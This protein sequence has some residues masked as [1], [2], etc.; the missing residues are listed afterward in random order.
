[1]NDP[2]NSEIARL[3]HDL[4]WPETHA[5]DRATQ[6]LLALGTPAVPALIETLSGDSFL[7]RIRAAKI[8]GEIGD[9]RAVQPLIDALRRTGFQDTDTGVALAG[10]LARLAEQNPVPTLRDALPLMNSNLTHFG[11]AAARLH[12]ALA[13]LPEDTPHTPEWE[14][15]RLVEQLQS[16]VSLRRD[17]VVR[18]L[19]ELGAP[20]VSPLIETLRWSPAPNVREA[21]SKILCAIGDA[22]AV[23]PLLSALKD[24]MDMPTRI[25]MTRQLQ[26]MSLPENAGANPLLTR[27]LIASLTAEAAGVQKLAFKMLVAAGPPAVP[28]LVAALQDARGRIRYVAALI[29]GHIGVAESAPTLRALCMD[30]DPNVRHAAAAV[31]GRLNAVNSSDIP[32]LIEALV[33]TEVLNDE[34]KWVRSQ[35][36][37]ALGAL[38]QQTIPTPELRAA[39]PPLR[40]LAR[41]PFTLGDMRAACRSALEKIETATAAF[42]DLPLPAMAAPSS[43]PENLPLPASA[44]PSATNDLPLPVAAISGG[45]KAPSGWWARL[46]TAARRRRLG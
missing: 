19:I 12:A 28:A 37:A 20:A 31:L 4:R 39:V 11:A 35:A 8:L 17:W 34:S 42:K 30:M 45:D 15:R 7:A 26:S 33:Q 1:M 9:A 13:P 24:E 29:L 27:P 6:A 23:E 38:A 10:G 46:K 21:A 18:E 25:K 43:S 5:R 44:P 22:R 2:S 41:S 14:A 36:V 32:L 40:R 3:I 16:P